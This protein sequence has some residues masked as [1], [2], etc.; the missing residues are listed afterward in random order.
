M[1]NKTA[2]NIAFCFLGSTLLIWLLKISAPGPNQ[3]KNNFIRIFPPHF[4]Q[5]ANTLNL[6]NA[7]YY[8][9]GQTN[10]LIY[11]GN[12]TDQANLVGIDWLGI[13]K[14]SFHIQIPNKEV[15][16]VPDLQVNIDSPYLYIN[17]DITGS[18]WRRQLANNDELLTELFTSHISNSIFLSCS[19]NSFAIRTFDRNLKQ[20]ILAK[21]SYK[22]TYL[23][24]WPLL[25]KNQL[26][27]V[28]SSDGVLRFEPISGK[29]V[30]VYFYCNQ[31]VCLD[32]N[33]RLQYRGQ[34]LDTN[35][36][37]K[38]RVAAI[39]SQDE[40]LIASPGFR[41]NRAA[42][43]SSD[44]IFVN[45]ELQADNEEKKIFDQYL[46]ID[47]YGLKDGHYHFS[48]YLPKETGKI[49]DM[50]IKDS[51]LVTIQNRS[52]VFYTLNIREIKK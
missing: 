38:I 26:E 46:V 42:C 3:Q 7:R 19:G 10:H 21:L 14:Y 41:E 29:F 4:L 28:F 15:S 48:F 22:S 8:I 34:T 1:N 39:P 25:L 18:V 30:Y 11:L 37:V 47:V 2:L 12:S 51:I 31:F 23:S 50:A 13:N 20:N 44:W 32:S 49:S 24:K 5:I 35:S 45:S 33:L 27:G 9:A 36:H 16:F 6:N 17:N 40:T 52:L 43:I